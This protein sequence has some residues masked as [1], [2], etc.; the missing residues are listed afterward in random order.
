MAKIDKEEAR[1]LFAMLGVSP[2]RMIQPLGSRTGSRIRLL[3]GGTSVTAAA[4]PKNT[5]ERRREARL[6]PGETRWAETAR[7]RPG[8]DVRVIDIGPRGVLIEAPIRLHIGTRVE[9]AL[10]TAETAVRLDLPGV[11]RRCHVANLSPLT[12]RGA[13][14]FAQALQQDQLEPFLSPE[15]ISA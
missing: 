1:E 11:V 9:L 2:E 10:F 7:L 4:A 5:E 14:E 3:H 12:Y 15:A 13:L 8:V 6:S